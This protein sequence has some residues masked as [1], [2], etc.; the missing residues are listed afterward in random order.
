MIKLLFPI[1]LLLI[2]CSCSVEQA[3]EIE[4]ARIQGFNLVEVKSTRL[5]SRK[6]ISELKIA[7]EIPIDSVITENGIIRLITRKKFS[8]PCH[9]GTTMPWF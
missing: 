5:F 3:A 8:E 1:L 6:Q 2:L 4:S 7:P 9:T